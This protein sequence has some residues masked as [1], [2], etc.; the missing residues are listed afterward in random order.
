MGCTCGA[1]ESVCG[2]GMIPCAIKQGVDFDR[3]EG[4]YASG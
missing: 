1:V 2:T 3:M 4:K